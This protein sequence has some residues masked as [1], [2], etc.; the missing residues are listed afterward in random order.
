[1]PVKR[2]YKRGRKRN[3]VGKNRRKN[4]RLYK[5]VPTMTSVKG[6]GFSDKMFVKLKYVE[7]L[8][9]TDIVGTNI[10]YSFRGNSLWDPNLTGSGHQPL[11][12]DQY[13]AIYQRYKVFASK[14]TV[15]VTNPTSSPCNMVLQ[16]GTD[17]YLGSSYS[18][19]LEQPGAKVTRTIP[20][21]NQMTSKMTNFSTTRRACG[22]SRKE[23]SEENYSALVTGNPNEIWYHNLFF[24]NAY[25]IAI[26]VYITVQITYYAQFYD[27]LIATQS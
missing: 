7:E 13:A 20:P 15:L 18:Q 24:Q 21:T 11:F 16:S 9:L 1:M 12:F 19:I 14:I 22:L 4:M 23:V 25:A 3:R 5:A 27:R 8:N 2:T 10:Y 6:N 17:N 26:N